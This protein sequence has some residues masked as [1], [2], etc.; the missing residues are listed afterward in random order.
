MQRTNAGNDLNDV[1]VDLYNRNPSATFNRGSRQPRS[2]P[3]IST[4]FCLCQEERVQSRVCIVPFIKPSVAPEDDSEH[5]S[6]EELEEMLHN[7]LLSTMMQWVIRI[8]KILKDKE[9]VKSIKDELRGSYKGPSLCNW[10]L[11][12]TC[13]SR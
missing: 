5:D 8:G 2:I 6:Y 13:T 12:L 4:N 1:V 7:D 10:S 9:G 11:L 3:I